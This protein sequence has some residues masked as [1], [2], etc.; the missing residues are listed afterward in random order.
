MSSFCYKLLSFNFVNVNRMNRLAFALAVTL[1]AAASAGWSQEYPARP[2]RMVTQFVAGSGGDALTRVVAPFMQELLGQPIVIENR[3]GAGGVQA[4]EATARAAP[5]GYTIGALTPNVPVIRV[6]AGTKIS[7]DPTKELVAV[8]AVGSTPSVIIVNPS[9]PVKSFREL[10]DYAKRN[11]NKLSFGT[12]GIGSAHHLAYEQIRLLT[13]VEMVHVPYKSGQQALLDVVTNQI[14]VGFVIISEAGTQAKAGKIRLLVTREEQRLPE[15][16][17][18]PTVAELLPGFESLPGW[19][20]FFSPAGIPP[21]VFRRL[22]ADIVKAL[23]SPEAKA[24]MTSVGFEAIGNTPEQF[25]AQVK[26]EIA[27][28][29][30]LAKAANI[31]L[32]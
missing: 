24:K 12:S 31:N 5:D 7:I 6:V 21:T 10:L 23:R 11:P 29:A 27:L 4:A 15:F 20:G 18:I 1:S 25:S 8:S 30:K 26:R 32:D 17:E 19:T 9:L 13:G 16:P 3:A 2:V 14:P 28:V 22:S